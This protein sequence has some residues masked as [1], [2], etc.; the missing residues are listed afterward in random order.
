[1]NKESSSESY[2]DYGYDFQVAD[3][4]NLWELEVGE[5]IEVDLYSKKFKIVRLADPE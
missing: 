4:P 5:E 2:F 3:I 1:M